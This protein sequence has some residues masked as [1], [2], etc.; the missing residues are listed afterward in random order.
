RPVG[1]GAQ[2]R[3]R[4]ERARAGREG[5]RRIAARRLRTR[6]GDL[7]FEHGD[8]IGGGGPRDLEIGV[9]RGPVLGPGRGGDRGPRLAELRPASLRWIPDEVPT[10]RGVRRIDIT[11]PV[12]AVP[13]D[14]RSLGLVIALLLVGCDGCDDQHWESCLPSCPGDRGYDATSYHLHASFD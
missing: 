12:V 7:A 11:D 8:R 2:A 4:A 13:T 9:R 5:E 14:M 1:T 3:D 10:R 6:Q